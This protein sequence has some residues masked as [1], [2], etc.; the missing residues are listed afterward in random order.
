MTITD[1]TILLIIFLY[2][3]AFGKTMLGNAVWPIIFALHP[4]IILTDKRERLIIF[5]APYM[6]L[7][8]G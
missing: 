3:I 4:I 8:G 1:C 5:Q 6:V 2:H 7:V